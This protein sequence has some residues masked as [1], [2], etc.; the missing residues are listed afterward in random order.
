MPEPIAEPKV[1]EPN[2]YRLWHGREGQQAIAAA[3]WAPSLEDLFELEYRVNQAACGAGAGYNLAPSS[4]R[5][6]LK[7]EAAE[8]YDQRLRR[9]KR[10][11]MAIALHANNE[12]RWSPSL[13]VRSAAYFNSTSTNIQS[14]ET[15]QRRLASRPVTFGFL[16]MMRDCRPKPA[17]ARGEHR[18]HVNVYILSL[19][20]I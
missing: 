1:A 13:L 14:V 16:R 20:H 4:Y 17:W 8:R 6:R 9:H 10:D 3:C 5:A 11:E 15:G 7:G 18:V 12:R 2:W 19:I